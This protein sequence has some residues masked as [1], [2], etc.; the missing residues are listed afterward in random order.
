MK[1][2]RALCA[3]A[4]VLLMS[5][6]SYGYE[7]LA[8]FRGGNVVFTTNA[9][10]GWFSPEPCVESLEVTSGETIAWRIER[11]LPL[12]DCRSDFPITYGRTPAGFR[13][14]SP[15]SPLKPETAY[16]ISGSGGA[17]Y[18]GAFRYALHTIAQIENLNP[19]LSR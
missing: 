10:G 18:R 4:P 15:P 13:Q 12:K 2:A 14:V 1:V 11:L 16:E 5:G 6:C 7:V 9:G 8:E 3:F 17:M 19:D